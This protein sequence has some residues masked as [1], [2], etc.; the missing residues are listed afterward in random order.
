MDYFGWLAALSWW[1]SFGP[2]LALADNL[3]IC[4][5]LV[6]NGACLLN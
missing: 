2:H 1:F 6:V 4:L 3:K 5:F